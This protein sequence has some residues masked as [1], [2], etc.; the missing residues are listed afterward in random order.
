MPR[1]TCVGPPDSAIAP[2]GSPKFEERSAAA[3][4]E[5][6]R[7][8]SAKIQRHRPARRF[9]PEEDRRLIQLRLRH[10]GHARGQFVTPQKGYF[11]PGGIGTVAKLMG[12]AKSSIQLRLN[13][14]AERGD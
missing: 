10:C 2:R 9:T 13:L 1:P 11:G 3:F 12:R 7:P 4:Q 8:N 14:L 5:P 6:D